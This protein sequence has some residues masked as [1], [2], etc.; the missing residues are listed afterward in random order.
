MMKYNIALQSINS[1]YLFQ[2]YKHNYIKSTLVINF[3]FSN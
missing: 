1:Y 3:L 2:V